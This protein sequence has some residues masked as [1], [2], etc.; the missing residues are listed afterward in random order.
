LWVFAAEITSII[1]LAGFIY[2]PFCNKVFY[3][4]PIPYEFY[5]YPLVF[6][7]LIFMADEIR[8]LF[9]RRKLFYFHK[10]GW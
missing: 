7:V 9:V 8:K 1:I 4:R 10:F 3:T 5:L 6:S 2:I